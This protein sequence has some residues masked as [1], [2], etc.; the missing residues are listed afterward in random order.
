ML[1]CTNLSGND[2]SFKISIVFLAIRSLTNEDLREA[3][4]VD[5]EEIP[6][7]HG[8]DYESLRNTSPSSC[9]TCYVFTLIGL[10]ILPLLEKNKTFI[11][12]SKLNLE[13]GKLMYLK[14]DIL[15]P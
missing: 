2:Y 10:I 14:K 5:I 1:V 3:F 4:A 15:R 8:V 7:E 12:P 6:E 13:K 9:K 11:C